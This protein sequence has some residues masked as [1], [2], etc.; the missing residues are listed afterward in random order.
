MTTL[1]TI[2]LSFPI[3]KN[4]RSTHFPTVFWGVYDLKL[5]YLI[6][7]LYNSPPPENNANTMRGPS[8]TI[9][10]KPQQTRKAPFAVVVKQ[11]KRP[12]KDLLMVIRR[13]LEPVEI[14]D[15]R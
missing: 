2:S 11:S 5:S 15:I 7:H 3:H 6:R 13:N 9:E 4:F 10:K 14:L 12:V 8:G 1:Y